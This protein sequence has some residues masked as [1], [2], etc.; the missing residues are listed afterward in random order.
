[1]VERLETMSE[2]TEKRV[3]QQDQKLVNE[4]I[5][6]LGEHFDSVFIICT[7]CDGEIQGNVEVSEIRG[8]KFAAIGSVW[9]F[10]ERTKAIRH[11]EG[12]QVFFQANQPPPTPE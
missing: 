2:E 7:R 8:N 4:C 3:M 6:K 1:M 12:H 9:S 10:L 11:A 5:D